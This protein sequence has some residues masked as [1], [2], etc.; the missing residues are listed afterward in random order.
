MGMKKFVSWNVNGIRAVD[1]KGALRWVD[2]TDIDF[3]ALQ[4]IKAEA[5]QIPDTIFDK[6][7]KNIFVNSSIKKGQSGV[8]LFCDIFLFDITKLRLLHFLYEV[9]F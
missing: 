7:Y 9:Q 2:D 3:L 6:T 8:A 1:K 5:D 4:E